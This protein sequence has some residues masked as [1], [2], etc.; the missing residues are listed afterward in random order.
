[1]SNRRETAAEEQAGDML[2]L[3]EDLARSG[4][5]DIKAYFSAEI[6]EPTPQSAERAARAREAI[7]LLSVYSRVR[8]TRAN[9][10]GVAVA[11]ARAMGLTGD[12]LAPLFTQL[13]GF[14][15]RGLSAPSA[16]STAR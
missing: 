6:A 8:A 1:M 4:V 7:K 5:D 10:M 9:E 16:R 11:M 12:A 2:M 3:A 13:T 15:A 14:S